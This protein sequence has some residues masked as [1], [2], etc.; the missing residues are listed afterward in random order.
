MIAFP[1]PDPALLA[2]F[3]LQR[4]LYFAILAPLAFAR[5]VAGGTLARWPALVAL[6]LCLGGLAT[7]F[8]PAL[9]LT[10]SA[11]Y[12]QA[13]RLMAGNGGMAAL[14][15]PTVLFAISAVL[16]DARWKVLDWIHAGLLATLLGL[17]W[18]TS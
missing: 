8:A 18:W 12:R 4:Y 17:W 3:V 9:G 11:A 10:G 14:L 15:V 2:F 16:P 7:A 13:A 1:E 6:A 5:V